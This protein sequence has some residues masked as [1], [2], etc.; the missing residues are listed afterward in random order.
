MQPPPSPSRDND[1]N[2]NNNHSRGVTPNL[3]SASLHSPA[4]GHANAPNPAQAAA[5]QGATLAFQKQKRA[6]ISPKPTVD[7]TSIITNGNDNKFNPGLKKPLGGGTGSQGAKKEDNGALLAATQA[8]SSS[9]SRPQSTTGAR[10]PAPAE[11]GRQVTGGSA[12][13]LPEAG[14]HVSDG[15]AAQRLT[16]YGSVNA[17]SAGGQLPMPSPSLLAATLAASRSA[18]PS[19]GPSPTPKSGPS[20]GGKGVGAA[21]GSAGPGLRLGAAEVMGAPDTESIRPTA[22]LVSLFEGKNEED[23]DPVKKKVASHDFRDRD[24]EERA[25][26][27][28]GQQDGARSKPKPKPKPKPKHKLS[29]DNDRKNGFEDET[30][31]FQG[32]SQNG[33]PRGKGYSFEYGHPEEQV[34]PQALPPAPQV[35]KRPSTAQSV[36]AQVASPNLDSSQSKKPVK[37]PQM[38]SPAPPPKTSTFLKTGNPTVEIT[39][40]QSGTQLDTLSLA[41]KQ[42]PRPRK[43]SE[44]SASSDDTFVSASSVQSQRDASPVGKPGNILQQTVPPKRST[45]PRMASTPDLQRPTTRRI[46]NPSISLDSLTNAIVASNI[47]SA[48]LPTTP[49]PT[50]PIPPPRRRGLSLTRSPLQPQRTAD[51]LRSQLTGG[52]RGSPTRHQIPQQRTGDGARAGTGM[53]LQTLRPQRHPSSQSPSDDDE[54]R[55]R[56]DARRHSHHRRRNQLLGGNRKHAYHE[57]SRRRWRDEITPRERKRYEAVWAS[58]RGLFCALDPGLAG[59]GRK[60]GVETETET[61][62]EQLVMDVVVRDIWSR[63]RLPPDE[64]AEVWEL[65]DGS[66]VRALSREEFVVGMWLIDQ[67]LRGRKIPARVGDSVWESAGGGGRRGRR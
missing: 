10:I 13:T 62:T 25:Q 38:E 11:L 57:G 37:T 29:T 26:S 50:P 52:S 35:D 23:T 53:L 3:V 22:S 61:E 59:G 8:V 16:Q 18:S 9:V 21:P 34:R 36:S 17:G 55:N 6:V 58:N 27:Q 46:S 44:S 30:E 51:S 4:I 31:P 56:D 1:N 67:R 15:L 49:Q 60:A 47:A 48:R 54:D 14:Y 43:L 65:V 7:S 20:G 41:K 42:A 45:P 33:N 28:G 40:A 19:R 66:G 39:A 32:V 64:L 63:S 24:A 2:N 5:L 12:S